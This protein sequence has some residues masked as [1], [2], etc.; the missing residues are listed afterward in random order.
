[1]LP[2]EKSLSSGWFQVASI[3][4][5]MFTSLQRVTNA[6]VAP[7]AK[8]HFKF[9]ISQTIRSPLRPYS[10]AADVDA[11][12]TAKTGYPFAEIEPK[13]QKYWEENNTFKTPERDTSKPKKYVLDMFPY[14]SGAGLHVG[15]PE[16]YTGEKLTRTP[17]GI[18]L[19]FSRHLSSVEYRGKRSWFSKASSLVPR[20]SISHVRFSLFFDFCLICSLGCYGPILEDDGTRRFASDWMG[21][22]WIAS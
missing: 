16:G 14:P 8:N 17:N 10:T 7:S 3:A 20:T 12:T 6:F 18:E 1:M 2:Q 11:P 15:H 22:L 21:L 19:N 13:W 4:M 5:L 9:G